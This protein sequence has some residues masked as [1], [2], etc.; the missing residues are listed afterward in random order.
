MKSPAMN[1]PLIVIVL[2]AAPVLVISSLS[3]KQ[4]YEH[5]VKLKEIIAEILRSI[6]EWE[7]GKL[8][9]IERQAFKTYAPYLENKLGLIRGYFLIRFL[10]KLPQRKKLRAACA[11]LPEFYDYIWYGVPES[12]QRAE[13]LAGEIKKLL[14]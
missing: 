3:D 12:R 7:N 6:A 8:G 14:K 13:Q 11:M 4:S 2:L 9:V 1:V 5:A 10:V